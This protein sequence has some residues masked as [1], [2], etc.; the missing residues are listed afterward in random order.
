[1][2]KAESRL[3]NDNQIKRVLQ[4]GAVRSG[5]FFRVKALKNPR[6]RTQS[7]VA[8]IVGKKIS[9][10]ATVR[11]RIKRRSKAVFIKEIVKIDGYDFAIFPNKNVENADFDKL[12]EDAR[13]CLR[14]LVSFS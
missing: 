7:R 12:T 14:E 1:M 2:I 6:L 10:K 8:V 3:S 11:N 4:R 13:K 5:S 9:N